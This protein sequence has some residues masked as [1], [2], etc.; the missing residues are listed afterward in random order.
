MKIEKLYTLRQFIKLV[1]ELDWLDFA[2]NSIKEFT[3]YKYLLILDYTQF[4]DQSLTKETESMIDE[5]L[6]DA[7]EM[8]KYKP[9]KTLYG[10]A[11]AT[12][13]QLKLKNIEI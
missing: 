12:N 2:K 13:G 4:L 6:Y 5:N 8:W 3:A 11:E 9:C 10:L 7:Y 1:K